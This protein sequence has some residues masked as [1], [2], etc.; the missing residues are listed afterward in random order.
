MYE[1][2]IL[3]ILSIAEVIW[4][5]YIWMT[6]IVQHSR[7]SYCLSS[8]GQMHEIFQS[9]AKNSVTPIFVFTVVTNMY[10]INDSVWQKRY[11]NIHLFFW[12]FQWL[13]YFSTVCIFTTQMYNNS[14]WLMPSIIKV[15]RRRHESIMNQP[16]V[17]IKV[18]VLSYLH[19]SHGVHF[20]QNGS[21][22][23]F[24]FFIKRNS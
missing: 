2:N 12:I 4:P 8:L 16:Q 17:L 9:F 24:L 22:Y 3:Q 14:C 7:H 10:I 21:L 13:R 5:K 20:Q 11:A 1:L 19:N 15:W 23:I 18:F 6:A